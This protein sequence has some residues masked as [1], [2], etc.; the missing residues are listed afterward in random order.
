MLAIASYLPRSAAASFALMY[1]TIACFQRG[2]VLSP[3]M[4]ILADSP[5]TYPY[6]SISHLMPRMAMNR[7]LVG[8]EYGKRL[9]IFST[10]SSR[11]SF[12]NG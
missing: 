1:S 6:I 2:S 7:H 8:S 5:D 11:D 3:H 9:H 12:Q 4:T 10:P